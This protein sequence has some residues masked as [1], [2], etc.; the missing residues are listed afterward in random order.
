MALDLARHLAVHCRRV[1]LVRRQPPDGLPWGDV[2]VI[3]DAAPPGEAHPLYGLAAALADAQSEW[4]LVCPTDLVELEASDLVPLLRCEGPC[5]AQ[6]P[7]GQVHPLVGVFSSSDAARALDGAKRG[8]SVRSFVRDHPR[9]TLPEQ[10]LRNLNRWPDDRVHP[11]RI[12]AA[13]LADLPPDAA[14]RAWQAEAARRF[15]A[16]ISVPEYNQR[17]TDEPDQEPS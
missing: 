5:V 2:R 9:V 3:R 1:T 6:T 7:D 4:V 12:L 10:A 15:A 8:H 16:G 14:R 17:P 11:N 13:V